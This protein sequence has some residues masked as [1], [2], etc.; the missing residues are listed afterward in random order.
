MPKFSFI[1][2]D[3]LAS[4]GD[5]KNFAVVLQTLKRLGFDGVEFNLTAPGLP[6]PE[7][8]VR[9]VNEVGLPIVSF[10]T[11][12]NYF[13]QGLCLSSPREE[14]R[15]RAVE[16]LCEFTATAAKFGAVMV[17]GQMQGFACDEPNRAVAEQRI[18]A[19][20]RQVA[21][22]AEQHGATVVLEPVNHL[23]C[24][25]HNTLDAVMK[26]TDRIASPRLKPMLDTFHMNV[27]EQSQTEPILRA[28]S[29]LGHFHLCESNGG[30]LG[31]GHLNIATILQT[32]DSIG[33][34]GFVS[35]KVYRE[36]WEPGARATM[37]SLKSITDG[38]TPSAPTA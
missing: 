29:K 6:D 26:L 11:G 10:L 15:R 35:V 31:S 27:E 20:L 13:G 4:F 28:G 19:G 2:C 32:L 33:Y 5:L 12:A 7:G 24:G 22:T 25:F 23:Q 18:E 9:L 36:A 17:V 34:S 16:A 8:L 30:L 21:A 3:S 38:P 1:L 14:I 37:E